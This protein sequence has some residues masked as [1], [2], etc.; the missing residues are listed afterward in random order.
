MIGRQARPCM[1][2]LGMYDSA[3]FLKALLCC[4]RLLLVVI[5]E[6]SLGGFLGVFLGPCSW[7][8][9]GGICGNPLWFFCL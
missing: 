6:P 2:M 3:W 8:F 7:G 5:S 4:S 1:N 9:A